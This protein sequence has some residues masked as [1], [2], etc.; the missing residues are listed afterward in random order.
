[1]K[2]GLTGSTGLI[3]SHFIKIFGKTYDIF[4]FKGDM[5]NSESVNKFVNLNYDVIFHL[6]SIIPKYNEKGIPLKQSFSSNIIGTEN[7][8]K[9]ASK[10]K[11]KIIFTS[12]QRVYDD[13]NKYPINEMGKLKPNN[14]Y[15]VSKLESERKIQQF[16]DPEQFTILRISNIYGTYPQRSSIIDSIAESLVSDKPIKIGLNP[17][18]LRDYLHIDDLL[19]AL[20]LSITHNGIF[21]ICLGKL[22]S[23]N[24]L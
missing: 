21:N 13:K 9:A 20:N 17:K 8:A 6:A 4:E 10:L 3:G 19:C 16:L 2:I 18:I 11:T 5:T 22:H 23:V 24:N 12:T 14:D 7:I 15:S 1:M